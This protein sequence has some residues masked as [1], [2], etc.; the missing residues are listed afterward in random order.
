[1]SIQKLGFAIS[2]KRNSLVLCLCISKQ[3]YFLCNVW[4]CTCNVSVNYIV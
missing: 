1:M 3:Q 4:Y 2:K